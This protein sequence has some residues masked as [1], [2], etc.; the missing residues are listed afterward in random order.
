MMDT[1]FPIKKNTTNNTSI[2]DRLI[3]F[4]L[5]D[6]FPV[7]LAKQLKCLCKIFTKFATKFHT[8]TRCSSSSF[9][10]TLSL[11][12]RTACACAQFGGCS[13]ATNGHSETRQT[14]VC[15]RNLLPGALSSRSALPVPVAALFKK[16]GL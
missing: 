4:F 7:C 13:S 1:I 8:H 6:P 14:A 15:C 11:I 16:F 5:G 3:S 12:Q 10:V 9:I 2:F